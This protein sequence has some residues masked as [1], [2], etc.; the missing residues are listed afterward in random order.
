MDSAQRIKELTAIVKEHAHRYFVLDDPLISDGEYDRLFHELLVIEEQHPELVQ[1]DSPTQRP[2]APSL[3]GFSQVEHRLPMLSLENAF[4]AEDLH[5]FEDRLLRF[6]NQTVP[7]DSL[8]YAAELKIDGLAVELIYEQ[9]ELRQ[10]STR[11]D[12]NRGE[13]ITRQLMTIATIPHQL[14]GDFPPFMEVRGEVYMEWQD[15]L[16]LNKE[17]LLNDLPPFVN[18]RNAAAGS[19]RQLDP[20]IT[21][22]RP[23]KF[24]AYAIADSRHAPNCD[25]QCQLLAWFLELGLPVNTLLRR[26]LTLNDVIVAFEEFAFIRERHAFPYEIDGMVVKVDNFALQQRL[27][28]KARAP[29]WAIACKFPANQATTRLMAVDFQV[30]RTGAIT[31]VAILE[32]VEVGGV[33]VS[34]AT[35][36][37]DDEIQRKDLRIGDTV[38]VQRA[39]DVIPE[40]V[41]VVVE[42]RNGTEQGIVMPSHCPVCDHPVVRVEGE[43][44]TRCVNPHCPAQRMRSLIHFCSK[45]GLDIDGLGKKNM[46]QL[47]TSGLVLDIPDIFSLQHAQLAVLEGWGDKSAEKVLAAINEAKRPPLAKFLAALGIRFVGEVTA[48]LLEQTLVSLDRVMDASMASLLEIEGIGEQAASSIV[49]YMNDPEVRLMFERLHQAGVVPQAGQAA[50]DDLPLSGQVILFTGT[51]TTLSRTEAKKMVKENGGVVATAITQKMTCLVAGEKAG[52]K[53]TKAKEL[54]KMILTEQE[55]LRLIHY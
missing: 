50:R 1:P 44:A 8:I 17:R 19:L 25:G 23:L 28:N 26:C 37:N 12:G 48:A 54:G 52:S 18:P 51:L 33:T 40:V 53:L 42:K 9:G 30:G 6:L 39:G 10:G 7:H 22:K 32:P 38:F 36:H 31:P 5:A 46:E 41:K 34:R 35:L 16:A 27:G 20:A 13:D 55:F 47:F 29:R 21:A 14:H 4:S 3:E 2:G 45:A 24:F 49:D 11:G 15:L 43:A